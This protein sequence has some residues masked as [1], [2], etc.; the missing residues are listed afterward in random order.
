MASNLFKNYGLY[1]LNMLCNIT[2]DF[3]GIDL[4][5]MDNSYSIIQ[6]RPY[7]VVGILIRH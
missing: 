3:E 2:S 7:G 6:G 1:E 4:S 5:A